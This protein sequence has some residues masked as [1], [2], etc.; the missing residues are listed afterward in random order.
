MSIESQTR[1]PVTYISFGLVFFG[2]LIATVSIINGIYLQLYV[3]LPALPEWM[4]F[5]VYNYFIFD[6][7]LI[8]GVLLMYGG[9]AVIYFEKSWPYGG[10]LALFGAFMTIS[11]FSIFLGALGAFIHLCSRPE[12]KRT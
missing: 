1:S 7:L 6:A 11:V 2:A 9:A 10:V 3:L 8:V 12:P 5:Q 4:R